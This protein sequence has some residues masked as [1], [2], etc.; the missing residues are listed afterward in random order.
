MKTISL[1]ILSARLSLV[2]AFTAFLPTMAWAHPDHGQQ[3][4]SMAHYLTG[5][6]FLG[7]AVII[8]TVWAATRFGQRVL[9]HSKRQR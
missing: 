3:A 4:Y 5:T 8:L 1:A 2:A 7:V 9:S 6:H